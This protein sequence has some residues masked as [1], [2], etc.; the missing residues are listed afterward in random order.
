M[1][2]KKEKHTRASDSSNRSA[3]R[4][5]RTGIMIHNEVRAWPFPKVSAVAPLKTTPMAGIRQL[6]IGAE[7]FTPPNLQCNR[8][9]DSRVGG[10]YGIHI[11]V[12]RGFPPSRLPGRPRGDWGRTGILYTW[13]AS[14]LVRRACYVWQTSSGVYSARVEISFSELRASQNR[15]F[16]FSSVYPTHWL[17]RTIRLSHSTDD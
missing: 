5:T 15:V 13:P 9:D 10:H 12:A 8:I 11:G 17:N 16:L 4:A 14:L 6:V 3:H 7:N 1:L 2:T